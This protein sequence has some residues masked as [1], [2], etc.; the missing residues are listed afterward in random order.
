MNSFL[1]ASLR[2]CAV[3]CGILVVGM[4]AVFVSTG[5]G[6][7]PL[8]YVHPVNEYMALLLRNPP[9]L[10]A[11][12]G[13]DDL[14]IVAYGA[15]FVLF[16]LQLWQHG[17]SR[18]L[19]TVALTLLLATA[20]LDM[21]EN[22]HFLAMLAAA[23]QGLAPGPAEIGWQ[24]VQSMFKFHVSY[25]GLFVL[26]LAVP[27]D[28]RAQRLLAGLLLFVQAPVGVAIYVV[29]R[30]LAVPLVFL[31]FAFFLASFVLVAWMHRDGAITRR[32]DASVLAAV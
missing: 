12:I 10:R 7:D 30:E 14:F 19:L 15:V 20:L 23:E 8:Q 28:T 3:L 27:R 6:Q 13:L 22:F 21:I 5:I 32:G 18:L 25:L 11:V 16:T 17:V 31:R 26:G 9:V 2:R 1:T 24:A 29:P 4:L